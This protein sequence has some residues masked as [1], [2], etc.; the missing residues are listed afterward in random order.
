MDSSQYIGYGII[1]TP[2][3]FHAKTA[4]VLHRKDIGNI[5][6][7]N[8]REIL[9]PYGTEVLAG[10]RT[11]EDGDTINYFVLYRFA[12]EKERNRQGGFYG[13]V[14]ALKNCMAD[15]F[16]VYNTLVELATNVKPYIAQDNGRFLAGFESIVFLKP[17]SLDE[18]IHSI[19]PRKTG[20]EEASGAY[21]GQLSNHARDNFRFID[22]FQNEYTNL[23]RIFAS[24]HEA[25]SEVVANKRG[26]PFL[27]LELKDAMI[28]KQLHQIGSL[29]AEIFLKE[30]S[31]DKLKQQIEQ[32]NTY[33]RS[34]HTKALQMQENL[35]QLAG[36]IEQAQNAKL[37]LQQ[38]QNKKNQ[39]LQDINQLVE[40]RAI[41][42]KKKVITNRDQED[43]EIPQQS[44]KSSPKQKASSKSSGTI[45][46]TRQ[47]LVI[48]A[49]CMLL[50]FSFLLLPDKKDKGIT[51]ANL[52]TKTANTPTTSIDSLRI[53]GYN[54][55][56]E[57]PI[58]EAKKQDDYL[59][60]LSDYLASNDPSIRSK[61]V[62][63]QKEL[64]VIG[65]VHFAQTLGKSDSI[66]TT[67]P[68]LLEGYTQ[69]K[70]EYNAKLTLEA[71][72]Q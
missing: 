35:K 37:E 42:E 44:L 71:A 23:G 43:V 39:L 13:S 5:I 57:Y 31:L 25:V 19:Q 17:D 56:N 33:A 40:Q 22:A 49:I 55:Q 65:Y 11:I 12:M 67:F 48:G 52:V 16:S 46:L 1:G 34:A 45:Q 6:D 14:I 9:A 53:L 50:L 18:L 32:A 60:E 54:I 66:P 27:S 30:Q 20:I 59:N 15:G 4:G 62:D 41:L 72:K 51:E 58:F 47:Q 68:V 7:L 63:L 70:K 38:Y 3:G 21:Y 10:I 28:E 36:N 29:D 69:L 24:K 8:N 64:L 2:D 26:L 61:A